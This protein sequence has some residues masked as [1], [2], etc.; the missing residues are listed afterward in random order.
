[1]DKFECGATEWKFNQ[2]LHSVY[3]EVLGKNICPLILYSFVHVILHGAGY[4][5]KSRLLLS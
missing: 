5:L 2:H 3:K 4:Y 1:V